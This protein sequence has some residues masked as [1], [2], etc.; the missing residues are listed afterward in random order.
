MHDMT[1]LIRSEPMVISIFPNYTV[2]TALHTPKSYFFIYILFKFKND[3]LWH[4][5]VNVSDIP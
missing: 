3:T 4:H 5:L 2:L 1:S